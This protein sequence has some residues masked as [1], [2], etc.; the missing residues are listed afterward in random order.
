ML[1]VLMARNRDFHSQPCLRKPWKLSEN[2]CQVQKSD[3][4]ERFWEMVVRKKR[5]VCGL[6]VG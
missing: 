5:R 3:S 1:S 2:S 4:P 6:P